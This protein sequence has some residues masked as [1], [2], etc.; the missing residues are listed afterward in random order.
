MKQVITIILFILTTTLTYGQT[1]LL[2]KYNFAEGGY[3]LLGIRSKSDYNGLADS[4]G[5][6]Y[7]N[8]INIL[9]AIKKE[10]V[11]TTP[12]PMY[13]CGYHYVIVVCRN[14]LELESFD[15]NLNCNVITTDNGYFYFDVQKL[16]KFKD[17]CKKAF[18][19]SMH[20]TSLVDARSHAKKILQESTLILTSVLKDNIIRYEGSFEFTYTCSRKVKDCFDTMEQV[21]AQLTKEIQLK[22][23]DELFELRCMGGTKSELF[24]GITCKESLANKFDLYGV[25]SPTFKKWDFSSSMLYTFWVVEQ[26]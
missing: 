8:D 22:Y 4:L 17:Y 9:N 18:K 7:I 1:K 15:I 24:I 26:K 23:P 13:A 12:S 3:Y 11:F 10:W 2:E 19:K 16:Q 5:N 25:K 20:F 21:S 6:F 14:G